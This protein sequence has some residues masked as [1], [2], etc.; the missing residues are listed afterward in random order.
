MRPEPTHPLTCHSIFSSRGVWAGSARHGARY[1]R[2]RQGGVSIGKNAPHTGLC[3]LRE[4]R[5]R[6]CLPLNAFSFS[7]YFLGPDLPIGAFPFVPSSP[8][9]PSRLAVLKLLERFR[10]FS[11]P[12]LFSRLSLS[13]SLFLSLSLSLSLSLCFFLLPRRCLWRFPLLLWQ[14]LLV[15]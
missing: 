14:S 8:L 11:S 10:P 7:L 2:S 9:A 3:V 4:W 12:F 5:V 6:A 13:L 15:A 1:N